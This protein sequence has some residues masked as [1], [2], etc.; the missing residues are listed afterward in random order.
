MIHLADFTELL[1]QPHPFERE[2]NVDVPDRIPVIIV[3]VSD[4]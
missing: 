3:V 1:E 4:G 2:D